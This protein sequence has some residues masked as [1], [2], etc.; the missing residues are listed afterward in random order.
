MVTACVGVCVWVIVGEAVCV[1][2]VTGVLEPSEQP[3]H[4]VLAASAA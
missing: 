1:G 2:V 4:E 3:T